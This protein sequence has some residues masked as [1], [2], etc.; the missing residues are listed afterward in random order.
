MTKLSIAAA[1]ISAMLLAG[2]LAAQTST[3][4]GTS[5]NIKM[6]HSE[7]DA[8]WSRLGG[9]A[10][11]NLAR[12]QAETS[13]SDFKKADINNDGKLSRTEF[14]QACDTVLIRTSASTG[15]GTG[16]NGMKK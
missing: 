13:V 2:P 8:V 15:T 11:D 7:C 6:S 10:T 5:G 1:A 12:A 9:P 3:V 14:Q 16:T 4:P